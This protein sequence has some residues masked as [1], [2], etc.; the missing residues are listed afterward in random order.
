MNVANGLSPTATKS[1]FWRTV[2][3]RNPNFLPFTN[4]PT[5]LR[6]RSTMPAEVAERLQWLRSLP[7]MR[8][9]SASCGLL[10]SITM[11]CRGMRMRRPTSPTSSATMVSGLMRVSVSNNWKQR[12]LAAARCCAQ[13]LEQGAV[14]WCSCRLW[15]RGEGGAVCG[16][17]GGGCD[18]SNFGGAL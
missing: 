11:R 18:G 7:L 15:W 10:P 17:G 2:D 14:L 3:S 4:V 5:V 16:G 9:S 12:A 8:C 1:P 6:S 13:G